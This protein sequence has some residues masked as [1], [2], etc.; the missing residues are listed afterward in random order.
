[1]PPPAVA[2]L[3]ALLMVA[4]SLAWTQYDRQ[5]WGALL[6]ALPLSEPV[7]EFRDSLMSTLAVGRTRDAFT[8]WEVS[9][10]WCGAA[11][12]TLRQRTPPRG[13]PVP[14]SFLFIFSFL[15]ISFNF[16]GVR[17]LPPTII[18]FMTSSPACSTPT[19]M[20]YLFGHTIPISLA[21][22][23]AGTTPQLDNSRG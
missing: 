3:Y 1:M 12:A 17:C 22:L 11:P 4:F 21:G 18:L 7:P 8:T 23:N 10:S 16:Q 2:T 15:F 14:L 5:H 6:D 19:T 9:G 20:I 13:T